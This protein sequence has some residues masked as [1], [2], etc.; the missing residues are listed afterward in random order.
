M[1]FRAHASQA[2][3]GEHHRDVNLKFLFYTPCL[4]QNNTRV[5]TPLLESQLHSPI[6]GVSALPKFV[7]LTLRTAMLR[8]K[9]FIDSVMKMW[10]RREIEREQERLCDQPVKETGHC[11]G[12]SVRKAASWH[13][14]VQGGSLPVPPRR[15]GFQLHELGSGLG[16]SGRCDGGGRQPAPKPAPSPASPEADA[17]VCNT[18]S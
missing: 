14:S 1:L 9:S 2:Y 4:G 11:I 12:M 3:R 6:V 5:Q 13:S 8:S 16:R 10:L 17:P 7:Q 15:R 18:S